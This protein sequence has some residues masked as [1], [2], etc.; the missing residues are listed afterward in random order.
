VDILSHGHCDPDDGVRL[1]SGQDDP[2]S[3]EA[4]RRDRETAR[5]QCLEIDDV[6]TRWFLGLPYVSVSGHPR[7]IQKGV[8]SLANSVGGVR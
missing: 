2:C 3:A 6:A 4:P 1:Q 5:M 8:V 7:H